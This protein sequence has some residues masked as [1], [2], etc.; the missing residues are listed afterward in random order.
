MESTNLHLQMRK[1]LEAEQ[2]ER[3]ENKFIYF[4]PQEWQR[5]IIQKTA[6]YQEIASFKANRVGGSLLACFMIATWSTGKYDLPRQ[7]YGKDI[8]WKW[9]GRRFNGPTR[10]MIIV[11]EKVQARGA[12]QKLLFGESRESLGEGA[13][14]KSY[15]MMPK[16]SINVEQVYYSKEMAGL[17]DYVGIRWGET[18]DLSF[19]YFRSQQQDPGSVKGDEFHYVVFDEFPGEEHWYEQMVTRI[20]TLDGLIYVS[21]TPERDICTPKVM[22]IA[23]RY[24][25]EKPKTESGIPLTTYDYIHLNQAEHFTKEQRE[26]IIASHPKSVRTYRVEG[27]F[28]FGSGFIYDAEDV[29]IQVMRSDLPNPRNC[30]HICG[31]DWGRMDW[32][33]LVWI[34]IYGNDFIAWDIEKIKCSPYDVARIYHWRNTQIDMK[35]PLAWG[36][37]AAS[38]SGTGEASVTELLEIEGVNVLQERA[39]NAFANDKSNA[40]WPGIQRIQELMGGKR[41]HAVMDS[42]MTAWWEEKRMYFVDENNKIP[43]KVDARFDLLD[44]TRYAVIMEPFA[45]HW[46]GDRRIRIKSEVAMQLN[47]DGWKPLVRSK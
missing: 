8:P 11:P 22:Q 3:R 26:R 33:A 21:A 29:D 10:G 14:E 7:E 41:F 9:N 19:I 5:R 20:Q 25:Q 17:I 28:V 13:T 38:H 43:K 47:T 39:H 2:L 18:K 46:G 30:R 37:D 15:P 34:M 4:R 35:I 40:V 36:W 1:M 45:E 24:L 12:M 44:A 23:N 31:M 6:H 42:K 27:R 16:G 32:G